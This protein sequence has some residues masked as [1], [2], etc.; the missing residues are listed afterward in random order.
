VDCLMA[1]QAG[2]QETVAVLGT[3]LTPHH[4]GLL[5]R[6]ADDVVLFFDADRAGTEAARRAEELL[7]QSADP[8]WWALDRRPNTLARGGLRLRVATLPPGHDPDTFLRQEGPAALEA[9]CADARSLLLYAVDRIFGE[10]DTTTGRGKATSVARLALLLSKVQDA[11]EAIGL[12]REA[13]RRLGI[14]AS[15]LW[16]Q[17]QRLSVATRRRG[18]AEA[19][20]AP[21]PPS[22]DR[23]LVQFI[24]QLPEA[25]ATL[26]AVADPQD[27]AHPA[28]RQILLALH[29]N[30]A[31]DPAALVHRLD[32]EPE[33][34]LLSRLLLEE[35]A[36][37]AP[38]ATI[39]DMRRRLERRRRLRQMR[40]ISQAIARAQAEGTPELGALQTALRDEARFVRELSGREPDPREDVR[41]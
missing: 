16:N 29:E 33:R 20:T 26:V 30:P 34:A 36:W 31:L 11:D 13:A 32:G 15:D 40:E 39:Q 35:R 8:H 10:E 22:F 41:S 18:V 25:R 23:D 37:S 19:P 2:F 5:R 1:H 12:G 21:P 9:R 24:V 4:L 38:A 6:Y 3:A 7:E 27:V 28:L 14:D 17:A